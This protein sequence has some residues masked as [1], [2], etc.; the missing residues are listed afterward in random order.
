MIDS[1]N[2]FKKYGTM[3]R[4][5]RTKGLAGRHWK[6]IGAKLGLA[7][8]PS[9]L[10]L[11]D[12]IYLRLYED[13]KM[14]VIKLVCEVATKEFAVQEALEAVDNEMRSV[15]FEFEFTKDGETVVVNKLHDL[16][17]TFEE[18]FLRISVLKTNPSS[19]NFFEKLV[20]IER[21]IKAVIELLSEWSEF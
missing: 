17:S 14:K 6:M 16:S 1:L 8:E 7:I 3:L 2:H 5:L 20:E 4:T 12:L 11:L 18:Y 13:S 10:S 15:E 21:I 9:M 19:Q